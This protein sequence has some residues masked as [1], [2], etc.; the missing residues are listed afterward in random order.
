MD[1]IRRRVFGAPKASPAVGDEGSAHPEAPEVPEAPLPA[2]P[3]V[4]GGTETSP[5]D[6]AGLQV[7]FDEDEIRQNLEDAALVAHMEAARRRLAAQEKELGRVPPTEAIRNAYLALL[8]AVSGVLLDYDAELS[9]GGD[10]GAAFAPRRLQP[11]L[12]RV[13]RE[14]EDFGDKALRRIEELEKDRTLYREYLFMASRGE[15][16]RRSAAPAHTLGEMLLS[17]DAGRAAA[18]QRI[19]AAPPA[20]TG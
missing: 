2:A 20:E 4:V 13:R 9:G 19:A 12:F 11:L 10:G 3:F 17:E 16:V 8:R 1:D 15:A 5:A 18:A 6:L 14:L 7:E